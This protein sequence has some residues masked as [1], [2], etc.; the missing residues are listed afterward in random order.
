MA[1]KFVKVYRKD[2]GEQV[3]VPDEWLD[4]PVLR[5]PFTR[6]APSAAVAPSGTEKAA[7]AAKEK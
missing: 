5:E 3:R 7:T 6:T 1:S 4:H 2:T